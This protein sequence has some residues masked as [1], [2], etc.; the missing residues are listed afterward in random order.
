LRLLSF[1]SVP[2]NVRSVAISN[3][4]TGIYNRAAV[5][6]GPGVMVGDGKKVP[7]P[8]DIAENW[9]QISSMEN[10]REYKNANDFIGDIFIQFQKK[11]EEKMSDDTG[12]GLS[13]VSAIFEKMPR[14]FRADA[15]SGVD[16]AFQFSISGE[17][18]GE[19]YAEIRE[20]ACRVDAGAYSNPT[21]T[22]R[23]DAADFLDMMSGKL[24]AMQAFTSGKLKISGDIMKAQLIGKL[25]KF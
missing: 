10:A 17:G 14:A 18:G 25:F 13:S 22:I 16:A 1:T 11:E 3:A 9:G 8:E 2:I 7:T 19:W 24:P 6:T 15:A 12:N 21:C 20:G 23:M 4:G 5:V